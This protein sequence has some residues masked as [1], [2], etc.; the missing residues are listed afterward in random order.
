[1]AARWV[2]AAIPAL[3]L[4]GA[5]RSSAAAEV[6]PCQPT[7]TLNDCTLRVRAELRAAVEGAKAAIAESDKNGGAK[8]KAETGLADLSNGLSSSM[9]DFLPLFQLAG[10]IGPSTLD[11]KTGVMSVAL[12]KPSGA[13]DFQVRALIGTKPTAFGP[14][15]DAITTAQSDALNKAITARK[16]QTD[17]TAEI[18]FNI[19]SNRLGRD[20]RRYQ[21]MLTRLFVVS[22]S[23]S[24][25]AMM[26]VSRDYSNKLEALR[27]LEPVV[28]FDT[29]KLADVEE[30]RRSQL[31]Q[32]VMDAE[33]AK[34]DLTDKWKASAVQSGVD[35][36]GQLINNQPQVHV[37]A[38]YRRRDEWLGPDTFGATATWEVPLGHRS[39]NAF[40]GFAKKNGCDPRVVTKDCSAQYQA[41]VEHYRAA[42]ESGTRLA[43]QATV[44]RRTKDY[45]PALPD[46]TQPYGMLAGYNLAV[47]ADL[48]RAIG[49][50][51][52]GKAA[53]RFDVSAKFERRSPVKL[54]ADTSEAPVNRFVGTVTLT[55]KVGDLSVPIALVFANKSEYLPTGK[56]DY[57]I[58]ARVGLKFNVFPGK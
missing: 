30:P 57:P 12:N 24:G 41:F 26:R 4:L 11:E 17:V 44:E 42:I 23:D 1:M 33:A 20:Y 43:I 15:T 28:A 34:A 5:P 16:N 52:A 56:N 47:A 51:D 58:T 36:F 6:K 54:P 55:K 50:D 45:H 13:G 32:V 27:R 25:E 9:K 29:T 14:L 18:A 48:G 35:L 21:S 46:G 3:L 37:V 40:I 49:V 53:G 39:L 19:V 38:S 7:E 8:K 22:T 31:A 2:I 10:V